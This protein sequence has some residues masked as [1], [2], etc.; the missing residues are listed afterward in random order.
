MSDDEIRKKLNRARLEKEYESVFA[1]AGQKKIN[2][3]ET[4][5]QTEEG[6]G[7]VKTVWNDVI[8]PSAVGAGKTVV[9]NYLTNFGND[10]INKKKTVSKKTKI[11]NIDISKLTDDQLADVASRIKNIDKYENYQ[12]SHKKKN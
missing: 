12:R 5:K 11:D 8:K 6:K 2:S 4:K 9:Q 3:S 10:L 7:F 1:K